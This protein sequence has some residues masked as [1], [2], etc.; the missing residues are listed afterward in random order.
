MGDIYLEPMLSE[1]RSNRGYVSAIFALLESITLISGERSFSRRH[2][3]LGV[4]FVR[5]APIST[6][7]TN[8]FGSRLI[9]I[10]GATLASLGFFL[11]R[12]QTNVY[13]YYFTIGIIGGM[14]VV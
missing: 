8:T 9:T 10:I 3:C 11:S 14:I 7:F 12:W 13:Y 1:L 5:L 4:R 6:V 2:C